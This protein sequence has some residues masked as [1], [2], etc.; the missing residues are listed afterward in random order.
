VGLPVW[1]FG[2]A[3]LLAAPLRAGAYSVLGTAILSW[4]L[5]VSLAVGLGLVLLLLAP[6]LVPTVRSWIV[7]TETSEEAQGAVSHRGERGAE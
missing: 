1:E 2:L 3:V 4:G 6:L 7:G 5:A